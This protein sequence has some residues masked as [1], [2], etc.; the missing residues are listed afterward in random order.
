MVV[1]PCVVVFAVVVFCFVV[2]LPVVVVCVR[3]C[4]SP[5]C[6]SCHVRA[7][8]Y[9]PHQRLYGGEPG[10]ANCTTGWP[11]SAVRHVR[12][13]DLRGE[14]A[15]GDAGD[16]V[17]VLHRPLGVGIADPD[18]GRELRH[19]AG[20]PRVVVAVGRARLAGGGP[21]G[22]RRRRPRPGLDVG[23]EHLRHG[24]GDLRVEHALCPAGLTRL[25]CGRR[26]R[27]PCQDRRLVATPPAASVAYALARSSG[28]T[29]VHA[30]HDRRDRREVRLDPHLLREARR[31]SP[32]RGRASGARRPCC[33]RAASPA[34]SGIRPEYVFSNVWTCQ[35]SGPT[36]GAERYCVVYGLISRSPRRV[37]TNILNVDPAWRRPSAGRS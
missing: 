36:N 15:A 25:P 29:G 33:R 14:R 1:V 10:S 20:E 22:E 2:V 19:E 12:V 37:R 18:D 32:A 34:V 31:P 28:L 4:R 27:R 9:R 6:A 11:L 26:G 7:N 23:G 30:Q 8:W 35:L 5:S 3:H 17:H 13:P 16:A 21:T 24:G